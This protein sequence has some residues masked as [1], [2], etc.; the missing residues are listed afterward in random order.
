MTGTAP[1]VVWFATTDSTARLGRLVLELDAAGVDAVVLPGDGSVDPVLLAGF[2]TRTATRIGLVASL[3]PWVQPPFLAARALNTLDALSR[4][5][6]GWFLD[7]T[8]PTGRSG[9]DSGR[10]TPYDAAEAELVAAR[11]DYLAATEAL[12]GSWEEGA[13][14]AD[15]ATGRYVDAGKVHVPDHRGP[16]FASRGPL[17]APPGP[18]GRPTLLACFAPGAD[19]PAGV[20]VLVVTDEAHVAA[21]REHTA[22]VLL[23][24]GGASDAS[25]PATT[26]DGYAVRDVAYGSDSAAWLHGPLADLAETPRGG[27]LRDRLT[28]AGAPAAVPT[29]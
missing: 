1:L 6:A 29:A 17:N 4:G 15:V 25:L 8:A 27:L 13:I 24:V 28:G 5:R 7:T 26:A 20:D 22:T 11:A 18:Q 23:A 14:V 3:S 16:Y 2:T 21:A 19:V 9:D 10:W 12:W